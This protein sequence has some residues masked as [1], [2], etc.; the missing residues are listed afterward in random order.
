MLGMDRDN[1][2]HSVETLVFVS[3]SLSENRAK[4]H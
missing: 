4:G 2:V 1:G 3:Y